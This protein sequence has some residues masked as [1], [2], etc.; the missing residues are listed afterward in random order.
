[1]KQV[2]LPV[3]GGPDDV[4][5]GEHRHLRVV[6]VAHAGVLVHAEVHVYLGHARPHLTKTKKNVGG[7]RCYHVVSRS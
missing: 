3:V 7:C 1:M 6:V 4:V 5:L 2:P